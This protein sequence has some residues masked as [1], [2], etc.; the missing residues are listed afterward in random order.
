MNPAQAALRSN[1]G[2]DMPRARWTYAA[3][4][5]SGRSGVHVA[6]TIRSIEP[7]GTPADSSA[8]RAAAVPSDPV[9]SPGPANRRSLMP[10]RSWIHAS[11]VSTK[12]SK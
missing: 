10:V 9:V 6:T 1:A 12:S 7:A 3:V 11:E 8:R 4:A 5:G 2:Q